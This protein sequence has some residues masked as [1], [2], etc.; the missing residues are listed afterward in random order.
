M[1]VKIYHTLT[2]QLHRPTEAM[3]E[4]ATMG[5]QFSFRYVILLA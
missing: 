4:R 5:L 3:R 1:R 2:D